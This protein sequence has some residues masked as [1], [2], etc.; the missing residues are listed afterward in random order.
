MAKRTDI[1]I[2]APATGH[3]AKQRM[4]FFQQE[5]WARDSALNHQLK[6]KSKLLLRLAE[7]S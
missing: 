1:E 6:V 7:R 5:Q 4:K 3:Y 2:L